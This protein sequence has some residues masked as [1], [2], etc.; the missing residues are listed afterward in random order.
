MSRYTQLSVTDSDCYTKTITIEVEDDLIFI[1]GEETV[2]LNTDDMEEEE[3]EVYDDW[4]DINEKLGRIKASLYNFD[5]DPDISQNHVAIEVIDY[6]TCRAFDKT[7]EL[8]PTYELD[9]INRLKIKNSS[10]HII[11]PSHESDYDGI[12]ISDLIDQVHK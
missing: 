2:L 8:A 12:D 7:K 5:F 6:L 9:D 3:S 1:N 10:K 4:Y 11:L